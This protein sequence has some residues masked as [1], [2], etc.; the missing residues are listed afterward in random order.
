MDTEPRGCY[1]YATSKGLNRRESAKTGGGVVFTE[2]SE[3]RSSPHYGAIG[4]RNGPAH[5]TGGVTSDKDE[6]SKASH[7]RGDPSSILEKR[8]EEWGPA[9][10]ARPFRVIP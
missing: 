6:F 3:G 7:C 1:C 2:I 10:N 8:H 4:I 9:F 5:L